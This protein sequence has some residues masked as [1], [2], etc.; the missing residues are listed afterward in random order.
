MPPS[1]PTPLDLMLTVTP[2]FPR[3]SSHFERF[4]RAKQVDSKQEAKH[5][6]SLVPLT[7]Q[8]TA[9]NYKAG[10][11]PDSQEGLYS[12]SSEERALS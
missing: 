3:S 2:Y 11:R 7:L 12:L 8:N 10:Q 5:L 6:R 9:Y 1:L 4:K